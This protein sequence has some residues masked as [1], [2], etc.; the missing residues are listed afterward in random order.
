MIQLLIC[1]PLICEVMK[2]P[3]IGLKYIIQGL[4]EAFRKKSIII[5]C[6]ESLEMAFR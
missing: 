2:L 6:Y 1:L 4:I 5:F 3:I